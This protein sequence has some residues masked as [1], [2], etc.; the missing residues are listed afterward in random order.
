MRIFRAALAIQLALLVLEPVPGFADEH[1]DATTADLNELD[2]SGA[3]YVLIHYRDDRSQDASIARFKDFAWSIRQAPTQLVWESYPFVLFD[4][5]TELLRRH[6]MTEHLAWEP[7][8]KLRARIRESIQV[9]PRGMTKKRLRGSFEQGF[10]SEAPSGAG[11]LNTLT[12]SRHWNVSFEKP[13]V[14][15]EIVDSLS[16]TQGLEGM[17]ESTVFE[18]NERVGSDELRGRWREA[19]KQ[20]SFRMLRARERRVVK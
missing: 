5:D 19:H 14:R 4:D 2:L 20:G 13:R 16:G 12:F 18:I 1:G 3:W 6:A 11:G 10:K 7:N 15:I 17:E 9:S 8:K